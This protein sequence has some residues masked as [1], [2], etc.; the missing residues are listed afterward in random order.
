M[1]KV[2]LPSFVGMF[3]FRFQLEFEELSITFKPGMLF[4]GY[5]VTDSKSN[6]S[7]SRL[8]FRL[9]SPVIHEASSS[10]SHCKTHSMLNVDLLSS[11][12]GSCKVVVVFSD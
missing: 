5:R 11:F 4:L 9:I 12:F 10:S 3:T 8:K 2:I 6:S 7:M 1:T